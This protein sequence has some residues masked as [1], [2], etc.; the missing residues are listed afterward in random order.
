LVP[1]MP[2][3]TSCFVVLGVATFLSSFPVAPIIAA[4]QVIT[5]NAMRGQVVAMFFFLASILGNGLGP[6]LVAAVTDYLYDNEMMVGI[7]ISTV[8]LVITP[9]VVLILLWGLKPYR[10]SLARAAQFA[11]AS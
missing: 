6:T 1:L 4:L 10:E 2:S 11:D 9:I 5:P 7:A 3:E 8:T